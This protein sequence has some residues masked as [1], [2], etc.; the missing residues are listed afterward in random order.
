MKNLLNTVKNNQQILKSKIY[1]KASKKI[2][3]ILNLLWNEN[4]IAGYSV[5]NK[6]V[7]IIKIF[8]KYKNKTPVIAKVKALSKPGKRIFLKTK[9]LWKINDNSGLLIISTSKGLLSIES[10]KN[11][12]IGG[13]PIYLIH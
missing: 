7:N 8:L 3:S 1:V 9:H 10:C 11:R 4:L 6:D 13:E 2:K 5:T 12:N